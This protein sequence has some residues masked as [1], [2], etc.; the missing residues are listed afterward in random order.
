V[1]LRVAYPNERARDR[2]LAAGLPK[3]LGTRLMHGR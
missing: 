3:P 2:I 1:V